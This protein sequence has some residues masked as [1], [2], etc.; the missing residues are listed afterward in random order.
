MDEPV[1][2]SVIIPT[3]RDWQRLQ[4]CL[5]ALAHQSMLDKEYE[6][7]VVNNDPDDAP[8]AGWCLPKNVRMLQERKPGAYAAR[9][10]GLKAA[11]GQ[12][13]AFTD[14]DCLPQPDWLT[15]GIAALVADNADRVAGC[16][17]VLSDNK[18]MT[19]TECYESLFAFDQ[20]QNVTRGVGVTA[21]LLARANLF[22][23]VGMFNE[24]LLSGGDIEWNRRATAMGY[25]IRYCQQAV[26]GHPA[27]RTWSEMARKVR[28]T[29]GGKLAI[30]PQ[31][32]LTIFRSLC[33]PLE[34]SAHIARQDGAFLRTRMLAFWVAYRIKV[35][36]YFYFRKL[37]SG[38][39]AAER[40]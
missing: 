32:R 35:F 2:V 16:I 11:R 15:H 25:T 27:R 37:K 9:N 13:L 4:Q 33:P 28:R 10:A 6:V 38:R 36:R 5:G 23:T 26:V 40:G 31:Y 21:N 3:Y 1:L 24:D 7:V 17:E 29:T 30:N 34:A 19:P 18:K 14:S 39:C 20:P 12:F 22:D 8:P